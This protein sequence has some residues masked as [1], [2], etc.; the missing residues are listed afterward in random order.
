LE[1]GKKRSVPIVYCIGIAYTHDMGTERSYI[2]GQKRESESMRTLTIYGAEHPY[3]QVERSCCGSVEGVHEEL[4]RPRVVYGFGG[5]QSS[6]RWLE[7]GVSGT[8]C[9]YKHGGARTQKALLSALSSSCRS[10]PNS[11]G[12]G[13]PSI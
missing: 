5:S 11:D 13:F 2:R 9:I 8:V 10:W 3:S 4:A 12:P 7:V 6:A 1:E